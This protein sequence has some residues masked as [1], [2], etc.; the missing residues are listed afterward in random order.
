MGMSGGHH[1]GGGR[2]AKLLI[3]KDDHCENVGEEGWYW[4]VV[5]IEMSR[6]RGKIE[7]CSSRTH[8]LQQQNTTGRERERGGGWLEEEIG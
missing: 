1:D 5:V 3:W 4:F 8:K 6:I 2:R 7:V